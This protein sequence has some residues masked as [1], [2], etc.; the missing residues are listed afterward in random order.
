MPTFSAA[1]DLPC[2]PAD[3]FDFLIQP[4]NVLK[5]SPPEF[6]G[7][8]LE[9]PQRVQ[10]GDRLRVET[11]YLGMRQ[12]LVIQIIALEP[13]RLL[14]DEQIEGPFRRY[15]H[16][17]VLQEIEGGVRLTENIEY[18]P[19]GGLLGLM[20]TPRRLQQYLAEAFDFRARTLREL[21]TPTAE[22]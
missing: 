16:E 22:G 17:R 2:P 9:A 14:T 12:L 5:L 20:V 13:E 10:L 1:L 8:L 7:R 18:E 3:L 4:A 21:L 15:R 11:R 6:N 19:P